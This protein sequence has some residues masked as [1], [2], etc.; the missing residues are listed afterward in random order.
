MTQQ[1]RTWVVVLVVAVLVVLIAIAGLGREPSTPLEQRAESGTTQRDARAVSA[2]TA[3]LIGT[4]LGVCLG[5][6]GDRYLRHRGKVHCQVDDFRGAGHGGEAGAAPFRVDQSIQVHF[7]NEK[8]VDTGLSEITVVFVFESGEEV[9]LEPATR[10]YET[11][12]S[13]RGVINLPSKT[14][15][16][17]NI[18]G[19][20][21]GPPA[22]LLGLEEPKAVDVKATFP[23]GTPYYKRCLDLSYAPVLAVE[24]T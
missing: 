4:L 3:T 20:F 2:P 12:T 15:A 14:W 22:K 8:E 9:V 10:G 16:S 6:F 5:L 23:G 24:D 18:K 1:V 17:V 7:F 11:S 19:Y 21:Y 13:P